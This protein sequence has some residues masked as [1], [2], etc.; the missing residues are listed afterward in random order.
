MA[1]TGDTKGLVKPGQPLTVTFTDPTEE[2]YAKAAWPRMVEK[3]GISEIDQM[4]DKIR[5]DKPT[6]ELPSEG[7]LTPAPVSRGRIVAIYMVDPLKQDFRGQIPLMNR[8]QDAYTRDLVVVGVP[9]AQDNTSSSMTEDEKKKAEER[10]AEVF[11]GLKKTEFINHGWA[12]SPLKAQNLD[13]WYSFA[14]SG[15][16]RG[17]VVLASTDGRI[18]WVGNPHLETFHD[19]VKQMVRADPAVQA[20]RKAE[21]A[22]AMAEGR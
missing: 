6:I 16:E 5:N 15:R 8:L 1:K 18:H 17:I 4:L 14:K 2:A 21:E 12:N 20:R 19:A 3:T 11:A 7:W 13:K 10:A 22:K 9:L